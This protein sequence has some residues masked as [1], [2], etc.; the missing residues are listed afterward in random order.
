MLYELFFCLCGLVI[1]TELECWTLFKAA[2]TDVSRGQQTRFVVACAM[3]PSQMRSLACYIGLDRFGRLALGASL[4]RISSR[5]LRL[6]QGPFL[7]LKGDEPDMTQGALMDLFREARV[8]DPPISL[9][10]GGS[11][12]FRQSPGQRREFYPVQRVFDGSLFQKA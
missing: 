8:A 9:W 5:S 4:S 7:G 10:V 1:T 11:N 12:R 6:D 2:K 3:A